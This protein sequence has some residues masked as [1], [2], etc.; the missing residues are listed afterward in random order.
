MLINHPKLAQARKSAA[1]WQQAVQ[2]AL[3][4]LLASG[5]INHRYCQGVIDNTLAWGPYYVVAPGVALPHAR[6]EQG[7]LAN[8]IAVTTLESPVNFGHEDGDPIWLLIALSATD[9]NAHLATLQRISSLLEDGEL[10]TQLQQAK[11]D[12]QLFHLLQPRRVQ[13]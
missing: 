2:I 6:P 12:S 4:P 10:L 7:V 1:N 11:T 9:A 5:R 8:G 3:N 13:E